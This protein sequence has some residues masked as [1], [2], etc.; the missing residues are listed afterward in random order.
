MKTIKIIKA[1]EAS[2]QLGFYEGEI[3]KCTPIFLSV[4]NERYEY[5][6]IHHLILTGATIKMEEV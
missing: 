6:G 4:I 1:T 3:Y 2:K 5:I